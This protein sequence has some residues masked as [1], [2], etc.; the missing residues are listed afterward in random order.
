MSNRQ[1][2]EKYLA[3][4]E[5][6]LKIWTDPDRVKRDHVD[7]DDWLNG[8]AQSDPNSCGTLACFGG[9]LATWPEFNALGVGR[10]VEGAPIFQE[11][12]TVTF[13]FGRRVAYSLFGDSSLFAVRLDG[14]EGNL[15]H[16]EL[17]GMSDH[18]VVTYRLQRHIAWLKEEM[19]EPGEVQ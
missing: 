16:A 13:S 12:G 1:R 5:L 14:E 8:A 3:N 6:A 19:R 10:G 4:A 2:Y 18:E 11:P 15:S 7:L 9:H 17:D